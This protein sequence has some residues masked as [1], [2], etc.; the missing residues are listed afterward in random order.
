M[1]KKKLLALVLALAMVF[2]SNL[3]SFA[4]EVEDGEDT[5]VSTATESEQGTTPV[6]VT[7]AADNEYDTSI[8]IDDELD[9]FYNLTSNVKIQYAAI[10]EEYEEKGYKD[11]SEDTQIV[12]TPEAG[13]TSSGNVTVESLTGEFVKDKTQKTE[14]AF[15]NTKENSYIEYTFD[16]EKEGLYEIWL[17]YFTVEDTGAEIQR[18]FE[19][20]GEAPFDEANTISFYRYFEED[21]EDGEVKVNAV[22][23]E[24]WPKHKEVYLWQ[25]RAVTDKQGYMTDPLKFYLSAGQH[26]LRITY[27]D[28]KMYIGNVTLKGAT[29]YPTYAEV[30]AEYD[31]KGYKSATTPAKSICV[32]VKNNGKDRIEAEDAAY[33]NDSTLRRDS[34]TDP[35][36]SPSSASERLL[37]TIGGTRWTDGNRSI[38]WTFEV[39]ESGLYSINMRA[40]QGY[41]EGMPSYRQISLDGEIPFDELKEYQFPYSKGWDAYTLENSDGEAY[42]FYLEKGEHTL[43]MEIKVGPIYQVIRNTTSLIQELSDLYM[44]I[45]KITGTSPDTNYEYNL[46]RSMP[47]LMGDDGE[48]AHFADGLQECVDIISGISN[49]TTNL[50]TNYNEIIST[51]REFAEDPDLVTSNMSDMTEAQTNLGTYIIDMAG[52]P[53]LL[54]YF[55]ILPLEG[56]NSKFEI[57]TSGFFEKC[58][59]TIRNF[60]SSFT[61]DYDAIGGEDTSGLDQVIDVWIARG[62]EWG[63][64]L[65]SMIDEDFTLGTGIGVNLNII[66]AGQLNA[67]NTSNLMLAV[68]SGNA[69]DVALGVDHT[70][71][72]EFAF[73]DA[74][75]DLSQFDN[76]DE[77]KSQFYETMFVPYEYNGGIFGFPETMD[78]TCLFYRTDIFK[79]L[80]LDVPR[81]WDDLYQTTLPILYENNMMFSF[82]VDTTASSNSPT[83]LRGM[84]M[85]LIQNGGSFYTDDGMY[86]ALD[87]SQAYLAFKSWTD[88]YVSYGLDAESNF[89]TEFRTGTQPVGV[90]TFATYIQLQEAAPELYGRWEIAPM[91]GTLREDGTIDRSMGGISTT[92]CMIMSQ[93]EKEGHAEAAWKFLSWW[94]DYETQI[95]YGRELEATIGTSARWATAN[96]DAFESLPWDETHLQII[97]NQ[98]AEA[99][100]QPIVLGGY[101]TTRHLVNAWNRVYMQNQNPRDALEEAVKEINKEIRNKHEEYGF[102]YDDEE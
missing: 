45:T 18:K 23:N 63:E 51:F 36:C 81:T 90:G 75:L 21:L 29:V 84:T 99:N 74:V 49:E 59:Y 66:P 56:D 13:V 44:K 92:S 83:S 97:K 101:F 62:T 24:V 64:I 54:D 95:K 10:V 67:G 27:V 9:S 39:E 40:K 43:T 89:F 70:S 76:F 5:E 32:N 34:D 41:S 80:K 3:V 35:K 48:F 22:K 55:E 94:M 47:E 7:S 12:L 71:P 46:Y 73:R 8:N 11:V 65:K 50:E 61:K 72:V 38:S 19:I 2:S 77:V 96:I 28:Q 52:Q 25:E 68:A 82:P 20:D 91:L 53:L 100:E 16:V 15:L 57:A 26:T 98:M 31:K 60:L 17:D 85:F 88:L 14:N 42:E 69:P 1:R 6:A 30:K 37:N 33:K 93:A 86:S 4:T 87:T 79:S 78:F 58:W 102:M